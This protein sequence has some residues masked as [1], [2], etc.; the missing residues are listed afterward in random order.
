MLGKGKDV[1][2]IVKGD[3]TYGVDNIYDIKWSEC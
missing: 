3:V 2:I 1:A